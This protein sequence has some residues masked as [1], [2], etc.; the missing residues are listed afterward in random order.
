MPPEIIRMLN[1]KM[2]KDGMPM[3]P[4][5][6]VKELNDVDSGPFYLTGNAG[7]EVGSRPNRGEPQHHVLDDF[8]LMRRG[9]VIIIHWKGRGIR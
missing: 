3:V 1:D 2:Q 7:M 4:H 5:V 8:L 6:D 9:N